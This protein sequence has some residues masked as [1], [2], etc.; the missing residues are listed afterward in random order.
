MGTLEYDFDEHLLLLTS[1]AGY[2]NGSAIVDGIT[3]R[4]ESFDK[5]RRTI[6]EKSVRELDS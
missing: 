5:Q 3:N 1:I 4:L 6:Y 2:G